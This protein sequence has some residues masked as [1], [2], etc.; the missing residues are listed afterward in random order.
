MLQKILRMPEI[1]Q[2]AIIGLLLSWCGSLLLFRILWT[3]KLDYSFLVWNLGLAAMPLFFSLAFNYATHR[4]LQIA[5]FS[6]WLLFFPNAPYLVTDLVH[7]RSYNSAPVWFDI[8][9]L[10]SSAGVGLVI[11]YLS[12]SQIHDRLLRVSGT[13]VAWAVALVAPFGAAFGI[14]LGRFLRWRSIDIFQRPLS[15][16]TDISNRLMNPFEHPRAWGVT[17]GFGALLAIG[18]LAVR[19]GIKIEGV[20]ENENRDL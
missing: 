13:V 7:L 5:A 8:L 11:T 14:Y 18:F 2:M 20:R 10:F 1:R 4:A 19:F 17:I 12:W 3:W 6:L 15:L 9:L 16:L